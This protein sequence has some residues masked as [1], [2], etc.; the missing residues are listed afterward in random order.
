MKKE[1]LKPFIFKANVIASKTDV[2]NKKDLEEINLYLNSNLFFEEVK[3]IC[4]Q[5]QTQK[6][7]NALISEV[8]IDIAD[9]ND[10]DVYLDNGVAKIDG[11]TVRRSRLK[12]DTLSLIIG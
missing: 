3:I 2:F 1:D 12:V 5:V 4:D 10:A 7:A 6:E 11:N 9:E 8:F